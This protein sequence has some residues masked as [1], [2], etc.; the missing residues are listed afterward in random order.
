M[1]PITFSH[2]P[3][4][5]WAK[6][7]QGARNG[8]KIFWIKE[9]GVQGTRPVMQMCHGF[10]L[11]CCR[12]KLMCLTRAAPHKLR[13]G[14]QCSKG[15]EVAGGGARKCWARRRLQ[16]DTHFLTYFSQPQKKHWTTTG[17]FW[18]P[19]LIY[20]VRAAPPKKLPARRP[21]ENDRYTIPYTFEVKETCCYK[22]RYE[23]KSQP[24]R[25]SI[26]TFRQVI[27][28]ALQ[29]KNSRNNTQGKHVVKIKFE[30]QCSKI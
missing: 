15:D 24:S 30:I 13:G 26:D 3:F 18:K 21:I 1:L 20:K 23:K 16:R 10:F 6:G 28:N 8:G 17:K 11:E 14:R 7:R 4:F 27:K 9:Q 2:P 22:Q 5:V 25:P 12:Q 29:V 19:I